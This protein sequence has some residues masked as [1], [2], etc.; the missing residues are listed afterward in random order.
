MSEEEQLAVDEMNENL[1]REIDAFLDQLQAEAA[2]VAE[3]PRARW[4]HD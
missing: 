2:A 4:G 3:A 1:D